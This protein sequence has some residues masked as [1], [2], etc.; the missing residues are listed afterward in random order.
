MSRKSI[1]HVDIVSFGLATSALALALDC[2][3][4]DIPYVLRIFCRIILDLQT[5]NDLAISLNFGPLACVLGF[6][7][8]NGLC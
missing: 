7:R 4:Y 2:N 6:R 1:D 5:G 8:L 3:F